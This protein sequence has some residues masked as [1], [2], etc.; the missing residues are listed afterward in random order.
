MEWAL[1][2]I[3]IDSNSGAAFLNLDAIAEVAIQE[4]YVYIEKINGNVTK[5]RLDTREQAARLARFL[6]N[7]TVAPTF[8][9]KVIL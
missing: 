3:K 1:K 2:V 7:S 9:G 8:T 4:D 6:N 5:A